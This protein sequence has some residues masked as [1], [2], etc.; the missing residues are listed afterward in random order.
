MVWPVLIGAALGLGKQL[1]DQKSADRQKGVE[2]AKARYSP[3]THMQAGNVQD[4]NLFANVGGGALTGLMAG[5]SSA[6]AA[7]GAGAVPA[8]TYSLGETSVPS[9]GAMNAAPGPVYNY[10][11]PESDVYSSWR[12]GLEGSSWNMQRPQYLVPGS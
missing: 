9:Q 5:G 4:P 3:W 11:D 1:M 8:E 6:P 2:A 7:A 12:K 10:A